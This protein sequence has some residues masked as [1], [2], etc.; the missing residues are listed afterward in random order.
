M[1]YNVFQ[2]IFPS[3]DLYEAG[4]V[5]QRECLPGMPKALAIFSITTHGVGERVWF[6]GYGSTALQS[7]WLSRVWTLGVTVLGS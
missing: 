7:R 3:G 1:F 4:R 6:A 5:A 2:F